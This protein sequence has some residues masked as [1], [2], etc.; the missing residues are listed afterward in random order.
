MVCRIEP[1]AHKSRRILCYMFRNACI[2]LLLQNTE[3]HDSINTVYEELTLSS[4]DKIRYFEAYW[5]ISPPFR[6]K[7]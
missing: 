3:L 5:K 2:D 7:P 1:M 4:S 6:Q